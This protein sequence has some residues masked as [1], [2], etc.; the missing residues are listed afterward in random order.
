VVDSDKTVFLN[1][2][3]VYIHIY[4]YIHIYIYIYI[5]FIRVTV[6]SIDKEVFLNMVDSDKIVSLN[7]LVE[8]TD[9]SVL[10]NILHISGGPSS[11]AQ[12]GILYICVF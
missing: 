7:S 6:I 12:A 2:I 1:S 3:Y 10:K 9:L 5:S 4:T 11:I 8:H